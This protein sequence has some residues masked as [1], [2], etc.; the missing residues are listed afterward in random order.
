MSAQPGM[1]KTY[2]S[3]ATP[4]P[5]Q[6]ASSVDDSAS[7]GSL[8]KQLAHEATAMLRNE[9]ALARSEARESMQSTKNGVA[10][11]ATGGVV[12]LG[13]FVVLL[14]AGVYALATTMAL[15]LSALIVGAVVLLAGVLMIQAGKKKFSSDELRPERTIDSLHKSTDAI[16]GRSP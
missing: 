11:V 12:A 1:D 8:L 14:M 7:V 9:V 15:W 13:G 3:Q 10:A 5:Y 4:P 2:R 6:G 16:R